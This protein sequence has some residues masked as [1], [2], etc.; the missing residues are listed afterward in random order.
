RRAG[1][2]PLS[3]AP[4]DGLA[5]MSSNGI[6]VGLGALVVDRA[7][8]L[9][10]VADLAA[11]ASLEAVRGNPS[12]TAPAVAD[13]KDPDGQRASAVRLRTAAAGGA[14][15]EP[16]AARSVQDALS[17]RVA[18]QVHGALL[19]YITATTRAVEAELNSSSDNPLVV[20][21]TNE[22]V[23]NGNFHPIVMA[24]AF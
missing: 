6:S 16:G 10:A 13:A 9:A 21:G 11:A 20:T 3:L 2:E 8:G 17:F 19:D 12:T 14:L 22:M 24:V 23:H 18:P 5:L 15:L 4:K 1:L 7:A